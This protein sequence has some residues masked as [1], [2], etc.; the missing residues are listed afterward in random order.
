MLSKLGYTFDI[1]DLECWEI[2]AFRT[3]ENTI[4]KEREKE[5]KKNRGK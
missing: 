1:D 4:N 3:I 2:D 5:L